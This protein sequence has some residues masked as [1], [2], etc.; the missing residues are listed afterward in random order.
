MRYL[1]T[2][3]I[4]S[5]FCTLTYTEALISFINKIL[6]AYKKIRK[7]NILFLFFILNIILL[8]LKIFLIIMHFEKT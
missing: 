4:I 2:S 3:F 8:I 1:S 5:L 7:M 6:H